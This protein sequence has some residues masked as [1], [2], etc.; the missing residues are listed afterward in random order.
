[1]ITWSKEGLEYEADQRH[2]EIILEEL[3]LS[4]GSKSVQT[5]GVVQGVISE[6]KLDVEKARTYRALAARANYLSQDRSDIGFAVK[7]LCRHMSTP[8][9]CD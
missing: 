1:M 5:P 3:G 4:E 8:R 7:E 2:V 6:E 9:V